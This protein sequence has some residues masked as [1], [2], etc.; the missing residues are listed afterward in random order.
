M[1]KLGA[2]V[3]LAT[4]FAVGI[5]VSAEAH[6]SLSAFDYTTE[7]TLEGTVTKFLF[8]NPHTFLHIAVE[9]EDGDVVEWA[10]EMSSVQNMA[11]R[12]V[13]PST[14]KVGDVVTVEGV[15]QLDAPEDSPGAR[16]AVVALDPGQVI[17]NEVRETQG[18]VTAVVTRAQS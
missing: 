13:R 7:L 14:F 9:G 16:E 5:V 12:G 6:H 15:E 11:R 2:I 1:K 4:G 18:S 10:A 8:G 3:L 17:F